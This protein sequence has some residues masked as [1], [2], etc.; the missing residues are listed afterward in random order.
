MTTKIKNLLLEEL[1]KYVSEHRR[2]L[3][4]EKIQHRTKFITVVLENIF[5]PQ[6]ASAVL[7]TADCLGIQS[8]HVIENT[9]AYK[10][11][12]DVALGSDK[13]LDIHYY[14]KKDQNN[15]VACIKQLK[16]EGYQ[17]VATMPHKK[18]VL[19]TEFFPTQKV[20]LIFGTE[21][22]GVSD[23]VIDHADVFLNI[24]MYGFTES[25]NI[26]VS[27]GITLFTLVEN[28]KKENREL[29]LTEE[30]KLDLLLS[31]CKNSVRM[32][33]KIESQ[34]LEKLF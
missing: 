17:I 26:S 29:S 14:K 24:P 5:Q 1:L 18:Q 20:A 27:A 19:L 28:L 11:N 6:N 34:F 32:S 31:W 25:Y 10:I 2:E 12:P 33:K 3:F 9:N 15:T 13:W 7:R 21:Q 4:L 23:D 22:D 16:Q 8:V 30:E